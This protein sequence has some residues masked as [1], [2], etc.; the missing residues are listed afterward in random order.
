MYETVSIC[1]WTEDSISAKP[2]I[3]RCMK[4]ANFIGS[5]SVQLLLLGSS[6]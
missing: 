3:H 2:C 5:A 6:I 4:L 1:L